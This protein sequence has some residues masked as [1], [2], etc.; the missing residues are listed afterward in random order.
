MYLATYMH[1]ENTF[2][3]FLN[4]EKTGII[5]LAGL[6]SQFGDKYNLGK[7]P[8][9]MLN[10]IEMADIEVLEKI[11]EEEETN[12][13][14]TKL[15]EVKLCAPIPYPRRNVFCIGK[16]YLDHAKEVGA[17]FG[18]IPTNP[19]IFSKLASPAI[20]DGDFIDSHPGIVEKL[21]YEVELAVVIG[22]EGK[23]ITREEAENYIFGYTILN[24]VSARTLQQIHEQWHKGKSLDT[25][26]P[27]GP[28]LVHKNEIKSPENLG[29]QCKVN[30]EIVQNSNTSNLIFDIGTIISVISQGLTL[31]PGDIIATGTPAGVALGFEP[32]DKY[33]KPGD[34][35]ECIIENIGSLKNTI[36]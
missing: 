17:V 3:G 29:I 27:M 7:V 16:N 20:G 23:D 32:E 10:F 34:V 25:F 26:C 9:D 28:F 6:Y 33:L 19:T 22:K 11:I 14:T 1:N 21:D 18:D 24:D 30:G 5:S 13:L 35:V 31:K 4:K 15:N 2:I 36:K 12:Q 8:M